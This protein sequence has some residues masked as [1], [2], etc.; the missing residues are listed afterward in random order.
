VLCADACTEAGLEVIT[1]P[2][3]TVE[4]LSRFLP[5]WWSHGNPVDLVAGLQEK[6]LRK[7]LEILLDCQEIDGVIM[8]GIMAALPVEYLSKPASPHHQKHI[9][10]NASG[11]TDQICSEFKKLAYK[12][13]KPVIISSEVPAVVRKAENEK[14]WIFPKRSYTIYP[15][16]EDAA[17]VMSAL[18]TYA[19]Y[20]RFGVK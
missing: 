9:S 13:R 4:R 3:E 11:M 16:P 10:T 7:S 8:L 15:A 18:A 19:E 2:K 14:G 6:D 5:S 17:I 20:V 12:Y 1:L